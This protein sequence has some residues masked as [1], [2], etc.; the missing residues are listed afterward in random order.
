MA[1]IIPS[2]LTNDVEEYQS[3]LIKAQYSSSIIQIDVVDGKFAKNT[4]IDTEVIKNHPTTSQLEVQLMVVYPQNYIDE[5]VKIDYVF[6]IIVPFE[7]EGGLP[8]AIYHVKNHGKQVGLSINP[9]TPL[10]VILHFLDD[11][12]L[13][14]LLAVDPGFSGQEFKNEVVAKIKEAKNIVPELAVE[15]DGGVKEENIRTLVEAGADF[16]AVGSALFEEGDFYT[17][18]EKLAKLAAKTP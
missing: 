15:V 3:K 7:V 11:I 17:Q 14:L 10:S 5:L 6:R 13:L 4:T 8:E 18:Y 12:D 9:E 1:V 16:L 2:I